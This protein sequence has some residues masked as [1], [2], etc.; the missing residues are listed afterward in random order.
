MASRV[1]NEVHLECYPNP[2]TAVVYGHSEAAKKLT[3]GTG[4]MPQAER[5]AQGLRRPAFRR[6]R[7]S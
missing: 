2:L 1:V 6:D 7:D 5:Q 3:H 4:A